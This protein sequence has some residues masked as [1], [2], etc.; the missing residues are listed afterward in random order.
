[1]ETKDVMADGTI[2]PGTTQKSRPLILRPNT[3]TVLA[4]E[5][6]VAVSTLLVQVNTTQVPRQTLL[7]THWPFKLLLLNNQSQLLL[8]LTPPPSNHTPQESLPALLV[9][10]TLTTQLLLSDMVFQEPLATT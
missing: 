8:K 9:E 7:Q 10:P 5:L 6:P 3:H 1:M 2:M 4:M